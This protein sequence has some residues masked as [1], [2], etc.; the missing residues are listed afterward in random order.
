MGSSTDQSFGNGHGRVMADPAGTVFSVM[1][2]HS[3]E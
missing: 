1:H 3:P 2:L